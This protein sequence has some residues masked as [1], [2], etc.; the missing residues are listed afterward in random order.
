VY[1]V[2]NINAPILTF[3]L[4]GRTGHAKL[5]VNLVVKLKLLWFCQEKPP[6]NKHCMYPFYSPVKIPP[7]VFKIK[8]IAARQNT[9]KKLRRRAYFDQK[10]H[11]G[12]N[13]SVPHSRF[14]QHRIPAGMEYGVR[15]GI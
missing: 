5:L 9:N 8:Y 7:K 10:A 12:G 2:V 4:T 3:Q 14:H 11:S 6:L 15:G 1:R 13:P